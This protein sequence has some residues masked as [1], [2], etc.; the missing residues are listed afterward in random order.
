MPFLNKLKIIA[1][2]DQDNV[3]CPQEQPRAHNSGD[4]EQSAFQ[5]DRV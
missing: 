1:V 2:P 3:G 5:S 4:G